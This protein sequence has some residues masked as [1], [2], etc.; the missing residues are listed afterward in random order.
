MIEAMRELTA[1]ELESVSG[2][3]DPDCG[4]RWWEGDDDD[5]S[6]SR[7]SRRLRYPQWHSS[8]IKRR[9]FLGDI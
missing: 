6:A 9:V 8:R 2:G 5:A 4:C 7:S 3:C 1:D